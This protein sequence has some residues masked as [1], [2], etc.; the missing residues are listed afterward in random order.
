MPRLWI[1]LHLTALGSLALLLHPK[2]VCLC[3]DGVLMA[4]V[5]Q[6]VD[7]NTVPKRSFSGCTVFSHLEVIWRGYSCHHLCEG[8]VFVYLPKLLASFVSIDTSC[9]I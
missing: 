4:S 1:S 2:L 6:W 9:S 8:F 3:C 7:M 5:I